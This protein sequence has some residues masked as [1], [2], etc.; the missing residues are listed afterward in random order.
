[1]PLATPEQVHAAWLGPGKLPPDD[2]ITAWLEKAEREIMRPDHELN[3]TARITAEAQLEPPSTALADTAADVIVDM[4]IRK[5]Q[6]PTGARSRSKGTGPFSSSV[7]FGG[8]TPGEL[9]ATEEE[10][11]KLRPKR[12]GAGQ[13]SLIPS[14]VRRPSGWW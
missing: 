14:T 3:L 13:I 1:M 8:T 11:K 7:M 9:T 4:V 6:N 12:S 10:L 5:F 2:K